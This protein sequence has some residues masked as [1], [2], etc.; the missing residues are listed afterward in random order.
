MGDKSVNDGAWTYAG[1]QEDIVVTGVGSRTC[2]WGYLD[3]DWSNLDA[4]IPGDSDL[5][6]DSYLRSDIVLSAPIPK[7]PTPGGTRKYFVSAGNNTPNIDKLEITLIPSSPKEHTMTPAAPDGTRVNL[8]DYWVDRDG[9][10]GAND[11]LDKTV[12]HGAGRTEVENW[13][14]GINKGR[15]LLFGDGNIHAGLWNKGAGAP[16]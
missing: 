14:K 11:L 16:Y 1:K 9:A 15:L 3:V 13:N 10:T 8:F 6:L 4:Q 12:A 2:S 7:D 5:D